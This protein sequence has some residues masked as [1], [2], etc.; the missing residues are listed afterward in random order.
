MVRGASPATWRLA[1]I[2]SRPSTRPTRSCGRR[3]RSDPAGAYVLATSAALPFADACFDVAVAYNSLQVVDD[4]A[5]TVSEAGRVLDRG[6]HLCICVAHPVTDLGHFVDDDDARLHPETSVLRHGAGRRHGATQR[7]H[8]ELPRLDVHPRAVL[9]WRWK[10]AGFRIESMR[11]PRPIDAADDF[12]RWREVPLF[13]FL[14]A[15]KVETS[16]VS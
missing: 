10:R 7:S 3:D 2:G 4:M 16:L 14:R 9:A 6:G 13:L 5:G 15:V 1:G 8:D 12:E 11:E